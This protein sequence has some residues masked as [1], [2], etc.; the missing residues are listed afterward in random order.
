[1]A[2]R[3]YVR[4]T[5]R[6]DATAQAELIRPRELTPRELVDAAIARCER[7]NPAINAVILPALESTRERAVSAD[8]PR[9]PFH[10]VPFLMK[11]LGGI[12]AGRR[13]TGGMR[14]LRDADWVEPANAC[15]TEKFLAAGLVIRGRE[16]QSRRP[17]ADTR[18]QLL[19]P[20]PRR[21]PERILGRV[22]RQVV[23]PHEALWRSFG[24]NAERT[25]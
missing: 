22:R 12:E 15:L 3:R 1:M 23:D 4:R 25:Q 9:G 24:T 14:C 6:L 21:A 7:L 19:R 10:G 17:Q 20:R 13:Y 16:L 18:A 2:T 5:G 11:E 8:L